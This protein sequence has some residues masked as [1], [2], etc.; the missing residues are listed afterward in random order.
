[1]TGKVARI[2]RRFESLLLEGR[3]ANQAMDEDTIYWM[4]RHDAQKDAEQSRGL[5]LAVFHIV[6]KPGDLWDDI[7]ICRGGFII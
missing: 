3:M 1:M 6:Y 7:L 5:V 2:C 4:L